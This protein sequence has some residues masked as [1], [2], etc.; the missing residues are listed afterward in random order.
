MKFLVIGLGSMGK[1]RIR[2]LLSLGHKNIAGFDPRSDR[3]E[4]SASKYGVSVF[5]SF[6]EALSKFSPD[7]FII[8]TPPD[9]HYKYLLIGYEKGINCFVEASVVNADKLLQLYHLAEG[10]DI[11][12]A[13]SCT[14]RYFPGPKKVKELVEKG[15]IGKVLN[16]NYQIGQYLPDWHPWEKIEEFYVSNIETGACR[17]IVPFELTWIN[18]IFGQ[19]EAVSLKKAKLTD[20]NAAIDDVYHCMLCYPGNV[21]AN[22]TVEVISRPVATRE[23]RILGSEGQIVFSG[24]EKCVRFINLTS[25]G[26]QKF[27]LEIGTVENNY[28]YPEE[29]YINEISTFIEA[30]KAKD[31]TLYP[32]TLL[33][34][35]NVLKVLYELEAKAS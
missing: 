19:P 27:S 10:K 30:V 21:L 29:P 26:W 22:I 1:R 14:M 25:D 11:L 24:E 31:K 3:T 7:I 32:N 8:S 17:E 18:N 12:L 9:L 15:Y 16:I 28:I 5:N 34:D 35:V 23:F 13:P 20:M 4:E 6:E 33:D 2:N